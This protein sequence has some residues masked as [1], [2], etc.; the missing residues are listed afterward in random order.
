MIVF[1]R[2]MDAEMCYLLIPINHRRKIDQM[3][4][5]AQQR[6]RDFSPSEKVLNALRYRRPI[7]QYKPPE[8]RCFSLP[9]SFQSFLSLHPSPPTFLFLFFPRSFA[10]ARCLFNRASIPT[11]YHVAR[12]LRCL[13]LLVSFPFCFERNV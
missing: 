3:H 6:F 2:L 12:I 4:S 7:L 8:C 1:T 10:Y 9:R 5:F 13:I 11:L